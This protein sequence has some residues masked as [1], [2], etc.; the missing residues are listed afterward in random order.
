MATTTTTST[1]SATVSLRRN[2]IRLDS[3][4]ALAIIDW[5]AVGM[6][7]RRSVQSCPSE[8][9]AAESRAAESRVARSPRAPARYED[10]YLQ[11]S[12]SGLRPGP[13][14]NRAPRQSQAPLLP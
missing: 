8:D 7:G 6:S 1:T 9:D 11:D 5:E 3:P 2:K 13:P 4:A 14:P 10:K 12:R